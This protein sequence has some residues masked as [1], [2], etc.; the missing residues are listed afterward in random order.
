[1][2]R[3]GHFE[4]DPPRRH[5]KR[6]RAGERGSWRDRL[7]PASWRGV[8]FHV[9]EA[10]GGGGGGVAQHKKP[11]RHHTGAEAVGRPRRTWAITG[12][13]LGAGY[14]GLRDRLRDACERPG[15]GKLVHPY[16][17]ELQVVCD[18]FRF[19]EWVEQG[20]I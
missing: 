16:L 9:E 11:Q 17:G 14:M 8:P 6:R 15:A 13:V 5:R 19:R 18:R 4:D 7:R 1:M 20:G 10:A 3:V 2:A 12:Y